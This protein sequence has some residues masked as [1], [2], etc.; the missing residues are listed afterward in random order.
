MSGQMLI[1]IIC[2][3]DAIP[4]IRILFMFL[5]DGAVTRLDLTRDGK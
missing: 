2:H 1:D 3:N 4:A 5:G